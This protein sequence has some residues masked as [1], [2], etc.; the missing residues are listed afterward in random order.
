MDSDFKP[1]ESLD[2]TAASDADAHV[3]ASLDDVQELSHQGLLDE[4]AQLKE[5]LSLCEG[6]RQEYQTNQANLLESVQYYCDILEYSAAGFFQSTPN[7]SFILANRAIAHTLGYESSADLMSSVSDIEHQVYLNPGDRQRFIA[8]IQKSGTITGFEYQAR[9]KDGSVIWLSENA[10]VVHDKENNILYYEGSSVDITQ[11]KQAEAELSQAKQELEQ[12]VDERTAALRESNDYLIAEIAERKQAEN[13]LIE[14]RQL[15]RSI[16]DSVPAMINARDTE[17]RYIIM[18]AY[19]AK[20]Y[21]VTP[22]QAIGHH[23]GEMLGEEY[24]NY[25]ASL[26]QQVIR[27]GSALPF[28][29]EEYSDFQGTPGTWL[30]TKVPLKDL[31]GDVRGVV[32]TSIDVTHLKQTEEELSETQGQLEAILDTIPGIVSWIDCNHRYR[33]VNHQ[34]ANMFGLQPA[35][36]IGKDIG[37]LNASSEFN[38]FVRHF[39]NRPDNEAFQEFRARVNDEERVYLIVVQKYNNGQAAFAVGIDITERRRAEDQLQA[40]LDAVPGIVSWISS[41]LKYLGVNRHLAQLFNLPPKAFVGQDIG[42]LH[43]SQEF[44]QFMTDLFTSS[45]REASREITASVNAANRIFL[46]MAQKYDS[47]KAA[48]TV[49]IDITEQRQAQQ[50]LIEAETKYRTIFESVVEGIF[51]TTPDGYYENANPALAKIYGYSS[52]DDLML[53]LTSIQNQL[54]VDPDRREEFI[55]T[56]DEEDEIYGFESQVYRKDGSLIWISEN[57]RAVRN[58]EGNV[59]YFEGTVEDITER[60][61]AVEALQRAKA[62]LES[63]VIERTQTLQE[64][65]ERLVTEITKRRNTEEALRTSEAELRALFSAMTEYIAVFDAQGN[66]RHVVSTHSDLLYSPDMTRIGKSVYDVLPPDKAAMFVIYIQR[67]LNTKQTITLEYSLPVRTPGNS[68]SPNGHSPNSELIATSTTEEAWYTASVS[69]MPDNCVIWVARDI[70]ER[71]KAE[72]ALREAEVKYRSIF[73][74]AVEGIFQT[75]ASGTV[76]SVNPALAKMYGYASPQDLQK[77]IQ[78]VAEVY[79]DANRRKHFTD[80]LEQH[81]SISDFESQVKRRDGTIIWVSETARAVR[82]QQHQLQY[83]EG[84]IQDVTTRKQAEIALKAEQHKSEELLLN[85]LPQAIAN[86]LK[87][88]PQLIADRFDE[89]TILFADI[90]DFTGF[91][92]QTSPTGLVDL[93]NNIFSSFDRLAEKHHLEKI[94]TVGDAYMVVGG[95][96]LQQSNHTEAIANL[97]LDMRRIIHDFKRNDGRPFQLRMGIH[98]GPVVAGVIG[99]KK[100]IYDLWGDTV[101]VASRMESQGLPDH[102]QVTQTVYEQLKDRY[103]LKPRGEI[104]VKGR[105]AMNSYWL[106]G[107]K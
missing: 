57:A 24:G 26:D 81:D 96:P 2:E 101:N 102:I 104:D 45:A 77:N 9:Q 85:I 33:G 60:K 25:T 97:A 99:I 67:A 41:D 93:L 22:A 6:E 18:N 107:R 69:P 7:G 70:T 58:S 35:D 34:L 92:A 4:I 43:T 56:L 15:L 19:Q 83:Y 30:T 72:S 75:T 73:E 55:R 23:A 14:N 36:F 105:G 79:V 40:A 52:V 12:K 42:F 59:A 39:F 20:L 16:I 11:Q 91:S 89:A 88:S 46:I 61:H 54:Y 10:R 78:N 90:V 3:E 80:Y 50:A 32:T 49:G 76:L 82:N 38:D 28:F 31:K 94:K 13:A 74:N 27:S 84:T 44:S 8:A 53:K 106:D 66:Y 37:F 100:F 21:G 64:L 48:F 29:E 87:Q 47:N 65:N 51:Q 71:R 63:K 17:S 5:K 103:V 95:V 62:E 86:Q 68:H 98:S 1:D